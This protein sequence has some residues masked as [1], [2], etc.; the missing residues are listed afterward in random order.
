MKQNFDLRKILIHPIDFDATA[1]LG[2]LK[3]AD[4]VGRY[5]VIISVI[6]RYC[7]AG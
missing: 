5:V 7:E 3:S 6:I 2:V 1:R 4:T